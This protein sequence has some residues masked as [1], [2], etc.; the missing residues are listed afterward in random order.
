M[1]TAYGRVA[2]DARGLLGAAIGRTSADRPQDP[3]TFPAFLVDNGPA[4]RLR[5]P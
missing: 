4:E 2:T 3:V 5:P 1:A